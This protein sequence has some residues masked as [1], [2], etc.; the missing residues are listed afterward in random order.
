MMDIQETTVGVTAGI[1][2]AG[3]LVWLLYELL[4]TTS[5]AACGAA[6]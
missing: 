2:V 4:A 6:G 5:A 3:V 1:V